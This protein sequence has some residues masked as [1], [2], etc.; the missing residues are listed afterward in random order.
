[1]KIYSSLH[2]LFRCCLHCGSFQCSDSQFCPSCERDLW[3]AHDQNREFEIGSRWLQGQALFDWFPNEDRKISKLLLSLKGGRNEVAF[4]YYASKFLCRM[5][6]NPPKNSVL[7]PC[8]ASQGRYHAQSW[9][10]ALSRA[11]GIPWKEG[12]RKTRG[13]G[14]KN[15]GKR[16]RQEI[17][18]E[19]LVELQDEHVIF[20]DDIVTTGATA[21]SARNA[22]TA[23]Q[24]MQVWCLAHRR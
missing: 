8:P 15:Q 16:A 23:N 12:F 4:E 1:M 21:Q 6:K 3:R 5:P 11:S 17:H 20:I 24:K 13:S 14:Q 9:A 2:R 18:M 19:T 22:L 7:I 10:S